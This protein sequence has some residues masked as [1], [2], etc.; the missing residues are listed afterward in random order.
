MIDQQIS[1]V[2][3]LRTEGLVRSYG[4][5]RVV[6]GVSFEVG[7]GEIVGLLGP[8]GAGKTTSFYMTVGMI[9]PEGGTVHLG[10]EDITQ[11]PMYQRARRGIGYLPQEPSIFRTLTVEQNITAILETL[12]ISRSDRAERLE[13]LLGEL[14]VSHVR[15]TIGDV[16][17]GG[18]R[19]RTEIAR[20]LVIEPKILLLDEPFSGIDPIAVQDIQSIL[21][22]LRGKG[23]GMLITDHNVRE[24]LSIADRAYIMNEGKILTAGSPNDLVNDPQ[25]RQVYFGERFQLDLDN[26][27]TQEVVPSTQSEDESGTGDFR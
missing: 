22:F 21:T 24:T 26:G 10:G 7:P 16:L 25:A 13:S 23:L 3:V 27:A 15:S 20:A 11:K 8:N 19:R 12:P 2:G 17:S 1:D 4:R 6:D 14:G 9:R 18:E 5:R